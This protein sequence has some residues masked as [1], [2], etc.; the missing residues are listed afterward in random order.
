MKYRFMQHANNPYSK[1]KTRKNMDIQQTPFKKV[2]KSG[3]KQDV[4]ERIQN[5]D[6]YQA[7]YC[8]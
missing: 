3:G 4:Q 1:Y 6:F 8:E 7:L 2:F 5:M